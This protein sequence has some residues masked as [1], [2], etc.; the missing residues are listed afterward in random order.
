LSAAGGAGLVAGCDAA[1]AFVGGVVS[2]VAD[3]GGMTVVV[4]AVIVV[5][6]RVVAVVAVVALTSVVVAEALRTLASPPFLTSDRH[7]MSAAERST[8]KKV[9]MRV[10]FL[11]QYSAMA[12]GTQCSLSRSFV[13]ALFRDQRHPRGL[14][15]IHDFTMLA[16]AT[17]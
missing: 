2:V 13:I 4:W 3:V 5:S 14:A 9:R 16:R 7:P 11:P 15:L 6:V 17:M 10:P 12:E 8:M 1:I